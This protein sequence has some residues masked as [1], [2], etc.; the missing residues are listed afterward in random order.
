V[1][2]DLD[3]G[4]VKELLAQAAVNARATEASPLARIVVPLRIADR[5]IDLGEIEQARKLLQ[6]AERTFK[7]MTKNAN[8]LG[9]LHGA[10]A[11]VLARIDLEA[12]LAILDDLERTARKTTSR[13]A[14]VHHYGGIACRLAA[15]SPA[16][17][18][19]VLTRL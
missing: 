13:D 7:E 5:L 19:R 8:R 16:D 15:H 6:E 14:T 10:I 1:R 18:E 17:A 2:R 11:G 9:Y 3:P 12:A 4:R